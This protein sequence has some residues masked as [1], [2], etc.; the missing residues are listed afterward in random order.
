[1]HLQ[2]RVQ[3]GACMEQRQACGNADTGT[4]ALRAAHNQVHEQHDVAGEAPGSPSKQASGGTFGGLFGSGGSRGSGGSGGGASAWLPSWAGG[5]KKEEQ[6][7]AL[8]L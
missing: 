1:M 6:K 4:N 8:L 3:N 7:V 5:A 2:Q